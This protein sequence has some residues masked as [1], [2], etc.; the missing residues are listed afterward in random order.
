MFIY[1][2][3]VHH[4]ASSPAVMYMPMTDCTQVSDYII[5]VIVLVAK[6]TVAMETLHHPLRPFP[7]PVRGP[8]V[9][10]PFAP[11]RGKPC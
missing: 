7:L 9:L 3:L 4:V 5:I 6:E 1:N 8:V 2:Y 11:V 10:S